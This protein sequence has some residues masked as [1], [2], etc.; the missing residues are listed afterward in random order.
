VCTRYGSSECFFGINLRPACDPSEVAYTMMPNMAYFEFLPVDDVAAGDD[1]ARS[2]L[3]DLARVEAGREYELVVTT[4]AGLNRFRVGDV[5]RVTGFH[6]AAPQFRFVC[7]RNVLLSVDFDKTD[8]AELQRAV[9]VA[10]AL[11]RPHGTLCAARPADR[12]TAVAR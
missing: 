5:L 10:S 7:R 1:D 4:Y 6:N 12:S 11:L 8:E 2:R 9:E 3:V